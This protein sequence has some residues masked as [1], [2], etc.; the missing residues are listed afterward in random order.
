M[1]AIFK[2]MIHFLNF[3]SSCIKELIYIC[4]IN[5]RILTK[6]LP[7]YYLA[8]RNLSEKF[9]LLTNWIQ[10]CDNKLK[11]KT[12]LFTVNHVKVPEGCESFSANLHISNHNI[13]SSLLLILGLEY[14]ILWNITMEQSSRCTNSFYNL[15]SE[16]IV[17]I[18]FKCA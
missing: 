11:N 14:S 4:I 5:I 17:Y 3:L 10:N 16:V 7:W 15:C 2:I 1:S 12:H 6:Y 13:P 9:E 8:P 18:I